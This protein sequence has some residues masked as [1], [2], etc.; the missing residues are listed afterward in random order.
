M[1]SVAF[2]TNRTDISIGS[3]RIW[4]LD[5]SKYLKNIG[6]DV[7]IT[8]N[9]KIA[10]NYDI[11]ICGKSDVNLACLFKSE[12]PNCLVGII[13]LAA[14]K[15]NLPIDFVIVGSIEEMDSLS[16]YKNVLLFPLIESMYDI[17]FPKLH[18]KKDCLR[19]GFHG[20]FTHLAKFEPGL[21]LALEE[22][23]ETV[24]YELL[25][26]TND[27]SFNWT[28]GKPNVKNIMVKN[29][30]IETIKED[31]TSCDIGIVPNITNFSALGQESPSDQGLYETDY[32]L[33]M[34]NKSNAGRAFVFHQLGIPVVAD[35]TPSNFHVMG[36]NDCGYLVS[37]KNGWKKALLKLVDHEKRQEIA[38]NAFNRFKVLYDANTWTM[39]LYEELLEINN[40]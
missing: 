3:H 39:N 19:I 38:T 29:W 35:L 34:K 33:R 16:S 32:I 15:I 2:L 23:A 7:V 1:K 12:N 25:V 31:L 10:A 27:K 22:L 24:K 8:A 26:I 17:E 20:S 37:S 14:D 28:I 21:R 9:A 4:V 30:N 36:G 6:I 18:S 11:V 40:G 5:L 13:N